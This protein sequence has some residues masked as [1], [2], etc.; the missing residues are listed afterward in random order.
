MNNKFTRSKCEG[1]IALNLALT[2]IHIINNEFNTNTL[3]NI[4]IKQVHQKSNKCADIHTSYLLMKDNKIWSSER[5]AGAY[6]IDSG[7]VYE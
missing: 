5:G 3:H 6:I 2:L 4:Y 7:F 1:L